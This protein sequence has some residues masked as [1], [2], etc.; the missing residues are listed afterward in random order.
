MGAIWLASYLK[1]GIKLPSID[2]QKKSV[3]DRLAWLAER[4]EGKHSKGASLIPFSLHY[5]DEL[6]KDMSMPL[7]SK[8]CLKQ[9]FVSVDPSDYAHVLPELQKKYNVEGLV[10]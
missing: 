6:L 9:W 10:G 2:D 8:V 4:T 7:S 5:S 1:G 3:T